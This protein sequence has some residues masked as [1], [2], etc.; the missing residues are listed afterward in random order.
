MRLGGYSDEN[1]SFVE[2]RV[3]QI[4]AVE[5]GVPCQYEARVIDAARIMI[6]PD[7]ERADLDRC[8]AQLH[9]IDFA[10]QA[11]RDEAVLVV[12]RLPRYSGFPLNE[13]EVYAFD[14]EVLRRLV[15]TEGPR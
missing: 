4:I 14:G 7:V 11:N 13:A 6:M 1:T 12:E 10:A 15:K 9:S 8:F 5:H 3:V 2:G